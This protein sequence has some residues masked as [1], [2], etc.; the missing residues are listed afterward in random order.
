MR[1]AIRVFGTFAAGSMIFAVLLGLLSMV[2]VVVADGDESYP[3][4]IG[5]DGNF[6]SWIDQEHDDATGTSYMLYENHGGWWAD[7]EKLTDNDEDDLLCWA[8][9]DANM[10]EWT[11]W[12]FVD[13]MDGTDDFFEYYQDHVTDDGSNIEYGLKWWFDGELD[14]YEGWAVEDV[15]GGDFWDDDYPWQYYVGAVHT[16][17]MVMLYTEFAMKQGIAVG[18]GIREIGGEGAH[19]VTCW[20]YNYDQDADLPAE[21]M[22]Y[23]Q[24]VWLTD[25]DSH[26]HLSDPDDYLL[27]YSLSY[28]ED[29]NYWYMPNYGDGWFIDAVAFLKPF[30]DDTRPVAAA[31]GEYNDYEGSPVTFSGNGS[32][33]DDSDSLTYRWDFDGDATWDTSW[34]SSPTASYTWYDDYS[35]EVYLEVFDGRLRDVD[36]ATVRIDNVA[37]TITA[38]GSTIN[39]N[40]IATVYGN[41]SDPGTLDTFYLEIHWGEGAKKGYNYTAGTTTFTLTNKYL[42]DN[43]TSTL[44]D[45]YTIDIKVTDDDGGVGTASTL[46][47]VNNVAPD[48]TKITMEQPNPQFILPYVHKLDFLGVFGDVGTQDTHTASWD[49]DDGTTSFGTVVESEGSGES[50]GSHIFTSPGTYY[51]QLKVTDDDG[52]FDT[53]TYDVV[54]ADADHAIK[55]LDQYIQGLDNSSF[56]NNADHRKNAYDQKLQATLKPLSNKAYQGVI[57]KLLNDIRAHSDGLIDGKSNDDWIIDEEAQTHICMKVDDIVAYLKI[58]MSKK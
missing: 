47:R 19:A 20:G 8:A 31:G 54:I 43:P 42:D 26:K 44:S 11:G 41:I 38:S 34:S 48:V 39:E 10:L 6:T 45:L 23:Y 36:I 46:V 50:S 12:G 58:L 17:G 2:P 55:D 5:F 52:G 22:T 7:A 51:V 37:P 53:L 14:G 1:S 13:G 16:P 40:G 9:T 33:D 27:Y 4:A 21:W 35:G 30:P 49:W 18:F 24:G 3:T 56:R 15:E 28:D 57:Q 25:S 32:T 29:N